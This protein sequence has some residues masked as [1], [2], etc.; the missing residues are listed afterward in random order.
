MPTFTRKKKPLKT[1]KKKRVFKTKAKVAK[2]M[3][4]KKSNKK[5]NK[6]RKQKKPIKDLN[7]V[8]V[9]V[10]VDAASMDEADIQK[11]AIERMIDSPT[12]GRV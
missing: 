6:K 8:A 11:D 10:K 2:K 4:V 5:I 3:V 1:T 9:D 12:I 7:E